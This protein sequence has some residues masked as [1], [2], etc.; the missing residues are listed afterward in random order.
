MCRSRFTQQRSSPCLVE[1]A[2]RE[3]FSFPSAILELTCSFPKS[4]QSAV[5]YFQPQTET[6]IP[7]AAPHTQAFIESV[8]KWNVHA[9]YVEDEL[10]RQAVRSRLFSLTLAGYGLI[11]VR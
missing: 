3:S 10:R 2:S 5:Y 9:R 6:P 11:R 1:E 4:Q 8:S 7:H